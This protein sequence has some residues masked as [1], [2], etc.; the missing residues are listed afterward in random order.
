VGLG[1]LALWV[2]A[3]RKWPQAFVWGA[4]FLAP[5][6]A[7]SQTAVL[8]NAMFQER[9]LYLP[10]LG[11]LA[12]FGLSFERLLAQKRDLALV[13]SGVLVLGYAGRTFV[14]NQ[15]W[16]N[17][18]TL[19]QSAVRVYP[20]SAKMQHALADALS[21]RGRLADA[22]TAYQQALSIR[23]DAL[24][25]NN[26]GNLYASMGRWAAAEQAYHRALVL[27]PDDVG[28]WIN[29][30]ITAMRSEKPDVAATAFES[31]VKLTPND[32]EG[33]Y[34]LGAAYA[35]SGK[36]LQAGK[37]YEHA[38]KLRPDW[39]EAFFNLGNVYRDLNNRDAALRA[40][41]QF[42]NLWHGDPEVAMLAQKEMDALLKNSR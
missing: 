5:Y 19:Y 37:A 38:V 36:L 21:E 1:G 15:D 39:A 6:V 35:A 40:Y 41:R 30:G 18:L 42:L 11:I 16:H 27:Q 8:I 9:F 13:L 29:R 28:A 14:R 24:T 4:L 7:V 2:L 22:E 17:D 33:Y 20:E 31:V 23:E 25:Y 12:L 34:N 26:L 32:P 3:W 10:L